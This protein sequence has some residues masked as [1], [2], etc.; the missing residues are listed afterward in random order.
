MPIPEEVT[1]NLAEV[2]NDLNPTEAEPEAEAGE[3]AEPVSEPEATEPEAAE[4]A[5]KRRSVPLS[6]LQKE[7][8]A[9]KTQKAEYEEKLKQAQQQVQRLG[10][11]EGYAKALEDARQLAASQPKPPEAAEP[12]P[13]INTDPAGFLA[14]QINK[15]GRE[16]ADLR[17]AVLA[18]QNQLQAVYGETQA[19]TVLDNFVGTI[20]RD[21]ANFMAQ[22]RDYADALEHIRKFER[23]RIKTFNPV[24][25]DEEV[26][27]QL[28]MQELQAAKKALDEGK[29]PAELAYRAALEVYGYRPGQAQQALKAQVLAA[30]PPDNPVPEAVEEKHPSDPFPEWTRAVKELFPG[31]RR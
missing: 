14:Y 1:D 23:A 10:H 27:K 19:K 24:A 13:D 9:W 22:N 8:E 7:R 12:V 17:Q 28:G 2:N 16:N 15:I 30:T 6:A 31:L 18:Q 20:R 5:A 4:P 25:S 29:S 11:L 26:N 3:V 21:E